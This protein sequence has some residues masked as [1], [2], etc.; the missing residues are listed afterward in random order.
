MM[1]AFQVKL[2][3]KMGIFGHFFIRIDLENQKTKKE[4]CERRRNM[5]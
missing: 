1:V 2:M 3:I 5:C 4:M